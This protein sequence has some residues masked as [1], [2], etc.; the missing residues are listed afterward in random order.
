MPFM[1]KIIKEKRI[2]FY[3]DW[4]GLIDLVSFLSIGVFAT[5]VL[6]ILLK[7]GVTSP[8]ATLPVLAFLWGVVLS[9]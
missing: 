3:F 6:V 9:R 7:E 1:K 2:A 8:E 5:A 4:F